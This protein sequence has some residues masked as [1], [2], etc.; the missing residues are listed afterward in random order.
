MIS[1]EHLAPGLYRSFV[2]NPHWWCPKPNVI[3]LITG[4]RPLLIFRSRSIAPSTLPS[5][6]SLASSKP[7]WHIEKVS[8]RLQWKKKGMAQKRS[9]KDFNFAF[10]SNCFLFFFKIALAG[11]FF[12]LVSKHATFTVYFW[13]DSKV[14]D[15]VSFSSI[16]KLKIISINC[17]SVQLFF[18]GSVRKLNRVKRPKLKIQRLVRCVGNA[19][20]NWNRGML[21]CN[22]GSVLK[23][24]CLIIV[25][26]LVRRAVYSKW[27]CCQ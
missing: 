3:P 16:L 27:L 18:F 22:S 7:A 19:K 21:S 15:F 9:T 1:A 25:W 26:V 13:K 20:T 10:S 17:K 2:T 12:Q 11:T 24:F 8:I 23:S 4:S 14:L 5:S 6:R